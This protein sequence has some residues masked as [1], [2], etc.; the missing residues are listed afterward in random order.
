MEAMTKLPEI[1]VFPEAETAGASTYPNKIR[2][3]STLE[4]YPS[5]MM[6]ETAMKIL[7]WVDEFFTKIRIK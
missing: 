6:L 7:E 4:H 2:Y 3:G 1:M 5:E